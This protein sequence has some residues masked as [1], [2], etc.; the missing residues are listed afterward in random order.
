MYS[1]GTCCRPRKPARCLL[2]TYCINKVVFVVRN[3]VSFILDTVIYLSITI[4]TCTWKIPILVE[5]SNLDNST[6]YFFTLGIRYC[7]SPVRVW[8]MCDPPNSYLPKLHHPPYKQS[9]MQRARMHQVALGDDTLQGYSQPA[10]TRC[11]VTISTTAGLVLW[12]NG[13]ISVWLD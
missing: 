4:I 1:V 5:T 10:T 3:V 7:Y 9:V 12:R 13:S 8:K 11:N 2:N 6:R